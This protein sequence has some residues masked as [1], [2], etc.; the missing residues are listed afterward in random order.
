[1]DKGEKQRRRERSRIDVVRRRNIG[2]GREG[3]AKQEVERDEWN[4][5]YSSRW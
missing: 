2:G 3:L 5:N 1:M 4:R